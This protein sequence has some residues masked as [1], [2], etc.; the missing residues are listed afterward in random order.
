MEIN[1]VIYF[2]RV[3]ELK[4][5]RKA[6]DVI[7]MSSGS[8]SKSIKSLEN[9]LDLKLFIPDGRNIIPTD[10]VHRIYEKSQSLIHAYQA[11]VLQI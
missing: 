2:S 11:F 5:I 4:S 10:D 9:E 8:L 1:K 6:A 7:G 3:Y